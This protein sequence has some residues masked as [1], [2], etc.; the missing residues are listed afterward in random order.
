LQPGNILL[1][2]SNPNETPT[3]K[4]CDF[5]VSSLCSN[6]KAT[7]L[8]GEDDLV[9]SGSC[10]TPALLPPEALGAGPDNMF[11][12]RPADVWA[13]GVTLFCLLYGHLPFN[14]DNMDDMDAMKA[15]IVSEK[16]IRLPSSPVISAPCRDLLRRM[17]NKVR[18]SV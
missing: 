9:F 18:T 15:E 10:G 13:C 16:S 1:D 6:L 2:K 8:L 5:G 12:G 4:L 7:K 14:V 3:V 11:H 17:L